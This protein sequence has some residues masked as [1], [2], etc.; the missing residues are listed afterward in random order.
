M[1]LATSL[2]TIAPA[3]AQTAPATDAMQPTLGEDATTQAEPADSESVIVTGTRISRPN[4][5][6][7]SPILTIGAAEIK[8]QGAV[9]LEE[10]TNRLGQVQPDAQQNYQ[11]S[12]GQQRGAKLRGLDFNRTLSLLNGQRIAGAESVDINLIPTSL[13]ERIDILTG[14]ASSVYGSDAVAGVV[15]YITKKDFTGLQLSA[16]YSVYNHTNRDNVSTPVAKAFGITTPTGNTTD[17]GRADLI[18]TFGHNFLEDRLNVSVFGEYRHADGVVFADRDSSG[19]QLRRDTG[20][21]LRVNNLICGGT[22][23][24]PNGTLAINGQNYSNLPGSPGTFVL[25]STL[26][27][28]Q[29]QAQRFAAR[30]YERYNAGGFVNF[31][32]SP[33]AEISASLLYLRDKSYNRLFGPYI[34]GGTYQIN[35]NNPFLSASQAQTICGANAGSATVTVPVGVNYG[36]PGLAGDR[37]RET[38]TNTQTRASLGVR[39]E[40]AEG[41]HYDVAG[42]YDQSR[43]LWEPGGNNVTANVQKALDVVSV[44]GVPTCR[45]VVNGTDPACV[46]LNIFTANN[47]GSAALSNYLFNAGLGR[48]DL[49]AKF[50]DVTANLTADFTRY[51]IR[52]PFAEQGLAVAVGA[53][54]RKMQE[55]ETRNQ[56]FIDVYGGVASRFAKQDVVEGNIEAQLPLLQNVSFAKLLQVNGGYRLSKYST[57]SQTFN[58]WKIEGVYSPTPDIEFRYSRNR[59]ARA[60]GLREADQTVGFQNATIVDPCASVSGVAPRA[61]LAACR[62]TGLPDNL[63]GSAIAP[64][65]PGSIRCIDDVCR[66]RNNGS[67]ISPEDARTTT[68]GV[69]LT[70]RFLPH[71]TLS[72]DRYKIQVNNIISYLGASFAVDGC[73]LT[74]DAYYCSRLVR[75][76]VTYQLTSTST[77]AGYIQGG[78]LNA[79]RLYASGYDFQAQ[80]S[81]GLG[82]TAGKLDFLMNGTLATDQ[83]SQAAVNQVRLNCVGYFGGACSQPAPRWVHNFRTTY[84][85]SDGVFNASVAWRYID[86][87]KAGQ[88]GGPG[89]TATSATVSDFTR[90][91]VYNYFDLALGVNIAQRFR[92]NASVNNILDKQQPILAN[93]YDYAL[94][95]GNT[96]PQRYDTFGRTI[97]IGVTTNF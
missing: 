28:Y 34:Q 16:S 14:G 94:S 42:V 90:I 18:A 57:N 95:R 11:Q 84:T 55:G 93:T 36:F 71:F 50:W 30:P 79:Y 69:V 12:N 56:R 31:K 29:N 46:P 67:P 40:I 54:Y 20:N 43:Q 96:I 32:A 8:A 97:T 10:V 39:G 89:T 6:S 13:V 78:N 63:Y 15:N 87:V 38:F 66:Q 21:P 76:P 70:P 64:G 24:G 48:S 41:W 65:L 80:Y 92:L 19:C 68:F 25:S 60:P 35:C 7:A 82:A 86:A 3:V 9:N 75:D 49:R 52:S 88:N 81:L 44:N 62:L 2:A 51:G 33:A 45:S 47:P 73:V 77:T 5:K 37:D 83:G 85:T 74:G 27:Q 58:T 61:S 91:P 1:A 26:P 22:T 59:A 17:G 23:Q 4:L 53:E 72:V